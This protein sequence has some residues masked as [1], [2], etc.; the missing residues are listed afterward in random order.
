MALNWTTGSSAL[1]GTWGLLRGDSLA[2]GGVAGR[3]EHACTYTCDMSHMELC[4]CLQV[5]DEYRR[6]YDD[7]RGGFGGKAI[8]EATFKA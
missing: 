4:M 5:R 7:D 8:K 3:Y 1:T 2:E 6:D